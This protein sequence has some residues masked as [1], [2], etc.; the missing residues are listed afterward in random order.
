MFKN[1]LA[2]AEASG[3]TLD[4]AVKINISLTDLNYFEAVN[5]VMASHFSEPYPARACVQV[6][7]LPR[8]ARIEVEAILAL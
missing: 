5:T 1:L 7:A 2:V 8:G 3:G 6:A 4:D